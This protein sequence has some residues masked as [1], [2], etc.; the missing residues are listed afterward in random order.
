MKGHNILF[1]KKNDAFSKN[2]EGF[3][4]LLKNL[5]GH[6]PKCPPVPMFMLINND[7]DLEKG[8]EIISKPFYFI[9]IIEIH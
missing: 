4:C 6:V 8:G 3:L 9:N 7:E 2:E 1:L 5:E